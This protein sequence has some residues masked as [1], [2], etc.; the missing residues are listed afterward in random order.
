MFYS[1]IEST[2][3]DKVEIHIRRLLYEL[4]IYMLEHNPFL[5]NH[6]SQRFP[7]FISCESLP[8][9]DDT[10]RILIGP[11]A[12]ILNIYNH[13][14]RDREPVKHIYIYID[15]N[16]N[17]TSIAVQ[18]V[19]R[20]LCRFHLMYELFLR[21]FCGSY[22]VSAVASSLKQLYGRYMYVPYLVVVHHLSCI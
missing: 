13:I 11:R 3:F 20:Q 6:T 16:I 17:I 22:S 21:P 14:K 7:H 9:R 10:K 1:G 8:R 19:A 5:T 18:R 4:Y 15:I 2:S 12:V